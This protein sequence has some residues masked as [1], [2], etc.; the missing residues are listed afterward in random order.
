MLLKEGFCNCINR[1]KRLLM[2]SNVEHNNARHTNRHEIGSNKECECKIG[3]RSC[4]CDKNKTE[5]C[6]SNKK[7]R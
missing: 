1:D 2:G 3:M 5:S 6:K 7:I 4:T